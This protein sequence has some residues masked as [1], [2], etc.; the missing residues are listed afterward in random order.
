MN[1]QKIKIMQKSFFLLLIT[2]LLYSIGLDAQTKTVQYED[3]RNPRYVDITVEAGKKY[4]YLEAIGADGGIA[5]RYGDDFGGGVGARVRGYLTIGDG[6]NQVP[7]GSIIR[8]IPGQA[9][10]GIYDNAKSSYGEGGGGTAVACKVGTS[11]HLLLVAGGGGGAGLDSPGRE[12][13]YWEDGSNGLDEDF[14]SKIVISDNGGKDGNG[15]GSTDAGGGG[16]Y[17]VSMPDGIP[18]GYLGDNGGSFGFGN[19]GYAYAHQGTLDDKVAAGGGGGGYSGGG[20]GD[21]YCGGGGGGSY[22]NEEWITQGLKE[23]RGNTLAPQDGYIRYEFTND[24]FKESIRLNKNSPKCL[25]AKDGGTSSGTNVQ[26]YACNGKAGQNW[27]FDGLMIKNAK[28]QNQCLEIQGSN[29]YN[30]AN[31]ELWTCNDGTNAQKWV[32]DGVKRL[33][34][35]ARDLDKCLALADDQTTNSTNIQMWD[36]NS[37]A[38]QQW[39]VAGAAISPT[40]ASLES[41]HS[42]YSPGKCMDLQGGNNGGTGNGTNVQLWTCYDGNARQQWYFRGSSIKFNADKDKCLDLLGGNTANGNNIALWDCN[43]GANQQW[44]YDGLTKTIRSGKDLNKCI[45]IKGGSKTDG[46]NLELWTCSESK[47]SQFEIR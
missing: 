5:D 8:F 19:G 17:K 38:N 32:Y 12:G 40:N 18:L 15:G 43:G 3:T 44:I 30:G 29:P 46:A 45:H 34:R 42:L 21:E 41:I 9:G 25:D 2:P 47:T 22:V 20:A 24:Y 31:V 1:N 33:I 26:L 37:F 13:N 16:G 28:D 39:L 36:C 27:V 11:W 35:S 14:L 23:D 4:V 7:V 10:K 6:P